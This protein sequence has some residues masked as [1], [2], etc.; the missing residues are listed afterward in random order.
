MIRE[1]HFERLLTG[2]KGGS[3]TYKEESLCNKRSKD[4]SKNTIFPKTANLESR[5]YNSSR[6]DI[7]SA[8]KRK[9]SQKS[10]SI[11]SVRPNKDKRF[12]ETED[13]LGIK[14][15]SEEAE[16][17]TSMMLRVKEE[18]SMKHAQ[19]YNYLKKWFGKIFINGSNSQEKF[20]ETFQ[21]YLH[22]KENLFF[23]CFGEPKS[24]KTF[25][26]QGKHLYI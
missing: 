4:N 12:R 3:F 25:S 13:S 11:K 18:M 24:G 7:L 19:T 5:Q 16:I 1:S 20:F 15:N 22:N 9:K 17:K 14:R 6:K 10:T 23:L 2:D 21:K 26:I 8:A